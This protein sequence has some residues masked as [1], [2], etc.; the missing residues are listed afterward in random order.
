MTLGVSK[1]L[2]ERGGEFCIGIVESWCRPWFRVRE[3][4]RVR[5]MRGTQVARALFFD[6]DDFLAPTLYFTDFS[7]FNPRDVPGWSAGLLTYLEGNG[8]VLPAEYLAPRAAPRSTASA[9]WDRLT[10]TGA[11]PGLDTAEFLAHEGARLRE[12]FVELAHRARAPRTTANLANPT[13]KLLWWLASRRRTLPPSQQ[14]VVDYLTFVSLDR[15]NVGAVTA[16]R[17]ALLHLCRVNR[18][19][20]TIYE[21]GAPLVPLEAMRRRRRKMVKKSAGLSLGMA[22]AFLEHYAWVRPRRHHG[23]QWELALGVAIVTAYKLLARYNDL[24]QLRWDDDH[25]TVYPLYVR[26]LLETRKNNQY[27]SCYID[28]ARPMDAG[29][30]GAYHAIIEARD[31]AGRRGHVLPRIAAAGAVD[32]SK[33]MTY[34]D[35][36]RHL[37]RAL[38]E[39]GLDKNAAGTFAGQSP[40]RA[41]PRKR[42]AL[43]PDPR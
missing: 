24:A 21:R 20:A 42:R 28:V 26:F 35:Y 25:Y 38:T 22:A 18:W 30:R 32:A 6:P 7:L 40:G 27:E 31:I 4:A 41:P 23:R 2:I 29:E 43:G 10:A 17:G 8:A 19:D 12:A 34:K 16:A 11:D 37:R 3:R 33:P 15:D 5:H 39:L 1:V 13:L 9:A 14:D 36:V